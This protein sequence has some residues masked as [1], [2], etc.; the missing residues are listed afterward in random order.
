MNIRKIILAILL[1]AAWL[2]PRSQDAASI[3]SNLLEQYARALSSKSAEDIAAVFTKDARILPHNSVAISGHEAITKHFKGLESI[4]FQE[5]FELVHS[6]WAGKTILA[7]TENRGSWRDPGSGKSGEF[8]VKGMMALKPDAEGNWKIYMYAY[9]DNPRASD[10]TQTGPI[11]GTFQHS[12]YV[13]LKD[14]ESEDMRAS[15]ESAL[16]DFIFNSPH[17]TGY[18]LGTPADTDRPII[19]NTY[20]YCMIVTFASKQEHDLYQ[21]EE[22]HQRFREL[23]SDLWEKVVIYDSE[24]LWVKW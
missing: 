1:V 24:N 21:V 11:A 12:V 14:P 16:E 5:S 8:S 22:G 18:H 23:T 3:A 7:Q 6:E 2:S 17:I 4:D 9:N 10:Q 19:D 20:T 15:F 13:W